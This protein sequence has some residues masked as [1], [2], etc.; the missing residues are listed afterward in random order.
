MSP[1]YI[2]VHLTYNID[3]KP[4]VACIGSST[5]QYDIMGAKLS[6]PGYQ[7]SG[8]PRAVTCPSCKTTEVFRETLA[9]LPK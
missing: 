4:A 6:H 1:S 5:I 2:L 8:D 7:C 9:R 3:G